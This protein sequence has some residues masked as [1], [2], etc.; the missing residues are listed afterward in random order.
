M[1]KTDIGEYI[2]GGYLKV[3]KQCDFVDYNVRIPGGGLKGLSELDVV[4]LDFKTKT[5][6]LCEV[7]T[8]IRGLLY[9]NNQMTVEKIK[10]KHEVQKEYA[11]LLLK[12]FPNRVYMFWSPYVPEGYITSELGKIETLQLVINKDYTRCIEEMREFAAKNTNDLGNPF[13]RVLQILEHLR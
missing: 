4:G 11:E 10:Q 13:L 3:I 8:H 1:M 7:T 6:Y 9:G 5:A 12:D 2:V